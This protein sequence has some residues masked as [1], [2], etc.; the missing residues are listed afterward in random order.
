MIAPHDTRRRLVEA[1]STL[2]AIAVP[3]DCVRNIPLLN[4]TPTEEARDPVLLHDK[5]LLITGVLNRDS[6]AFEAARQA[7]EAGAE[8]VL[9]GFGR[10]K[11]LTDRAANQLPQPADVLELDVNSASDLEAVAADLGERWGR[12]DGVLH[13]IAFAPE[14]ALGGKFL[15][16][17]PESAV[18]AFTTSAFSLKSLAVALRDLYPESGASV[19]G[20]DFDASVAWPV[21]DW[22]GVAKAAL[23]ATSRYLARDLG[24]RGVRVNLVSAG[25][26]GTLAARGI[27]G[28]ASL[29][30]MW[31]QQAPLGWDTEDAG[32]VAGA[33]L[34]LLSDLSRAITGEI[35]HVDGG[36]HAMGAPIA[37]AAAEDRG[38]GR[39]PM[40]R[41][42][43]L[44]TGATGFL[45]MEVLARLLEHDDREVLALV[46]A[47]DTAGAEAR[48][49]GVLRRL[50]R[51]RPPVPRARARVPADLT[52]PASGS[53]APA[54]RDARRPRRH[55]PALRGVDLVRPA[56]GRGARDQRRG[57]APGASRWP[58]RRASAARCSASSTSRPP[59]SSGRHAGLF[60]E[61]QLD[62]GQAFRNTYEQT[63]YEA[64]HLVARGRATCAGDRA[65][66]HRDGRGRDRLDAGVQRPLLAAARVRP[67]AVR[68][69][70]DAPDGRVDIVP[71]DYVADALV[72]LIDRPEAGVFNLV[73]GHDAA[74]VDQLAELACAHFDR[75]RPPF[76][77]PGTGPAR[78]RRTSTA[79]STSRTST[80]T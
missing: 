14:D 18:T 69:G 23:E 19:V 71:A 68:G 42:S 24:P 56:A 57:H 40:S 77:E 60:R 37:E 73:S 32:P 67:R 44:L 39:G 9:T 34:F 49:D 61:R 54:A 63:K 38:G 17:P 78:R 29:A 15:S 22:M 30:D 53:R 31:S 5:K 27:P 47:A 8:V 62:V 76:V 80:W 25:P 28:F 13:A 16:T 4:P 58:A 20:M 33:I 64:E 75:P 55:G 11:R 79:P 41:G 51:D 65:A 66:E 46:R 52:G 1:L 6:I 10:A 3:A 26:L 21:Y 12:V 36:F 59:T 50:W 7:Q 45:G 74:T 2:D 35:I 70:A 72:H 48:I 43:I